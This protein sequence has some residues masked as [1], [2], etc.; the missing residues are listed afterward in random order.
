MM[1]T[2]LRSPVANGDL[3]RVPGAEVEA[4]LLGIG[5][6]E[7][8][9]PEHDRSGERVCAWVLVRVNVRKD[10]APRACGPNVCLFGRRQARREAGEAVAVVSRRRP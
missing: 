7:P 3:E 9:A 6:D 10:F 8:A 5:D 4:G 2:R 1:V